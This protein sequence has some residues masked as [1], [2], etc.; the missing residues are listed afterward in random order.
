LLVIDIDYN[1]YWV[2]K[3]VLESR[4]Y[5]P[6]VV[7]VEVNSGVR[8]SATESKTVRYDPSHV[9][10]MTDYYG[11]TVAAFAKLGRQ[12][13]YSLVYCE[14]HGVNCFFVHESATPGVD[15]QAL[16]AD[17]GVGVVEIYRPPNHFGKGKRHAPDTTGRQWVRV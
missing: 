2:W 17:A 9:W 8:G 15:L 7:V 14:S 13:G 6:R 5:Q 1:D 16:L 12:F 3:A 10:D 11:G 4:L